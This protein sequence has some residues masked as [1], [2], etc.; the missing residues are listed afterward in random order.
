MAGLT[1]QPITIGGKDGV[2]LYLDER[3]MPVPPDKATLAQVRFA[4]GRVSF[5]RV[6]PRESAPPRRTS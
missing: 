4:D 6:S 3:F 5:Y 2:V 1:P